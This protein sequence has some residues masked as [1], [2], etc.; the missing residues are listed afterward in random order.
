MKVLKGIAHN[1]FYSHVNYSVTKIVE[2]EEKAAVAFYSHVN[3]SVTKIQ[4]CSV[5]I[6][7]GFTVT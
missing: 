3:Y 1:E 6:Q 4:E 5:V 7:L 2:I